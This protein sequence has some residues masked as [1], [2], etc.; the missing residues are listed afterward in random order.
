MGAPGVPGLLLAR[1]LEQL[2]GQ[3]DAGHAQAPPGQ[4]A[5]VTTCAAPTSST[6]CPA[7]TPRRSQRTA[8]CALGLR[9]VAVGIHVQVDPFEGLDEPGRL[10]LGRL[11]RRAPHARRCAA[12]TTASRQ[13]PDS[14]WGK[15]MLREALTTTPLP[16]SRWVAATSRA[17]APCAP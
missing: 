1:L 14:A 4:G 10:T 2:G 3:V 7:R 11:H 9:V 8:A 15:V 16:S 12:A 5:R 17:V 6:R 13:R